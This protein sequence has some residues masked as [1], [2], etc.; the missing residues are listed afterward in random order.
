MAITLKQA[1]ALNG[2]PDLDSFND[3]QEQC[4]NTDY[5][6][7]SKPI[8]HLSSWEGYWYVAGYDL[9]ISLSSTSVAATGGTITVTYTIKEHR[10]TGDVLVSG[11][12]PTVTSTLGTVS[13]ITTTNTSGVGTATITIDN[14]KSL[15]SKS[16]KVTV[17]ST[18]GGSVISKES[19]ATQAA[20]YYTYGSITINTFTY[21]AVGAAGGTSSPSITY[22]QPYGWNGSTSGAGTINGNGDDDY[23][24]YKETGAHSALTVNGSTG[25]VTWTKNNATAN[26][27]DA[28]RSG[29]ITAT[30]TRNGKTAT[31]EVT[32][33][34]NA[35]K[36]SSYGAW[37]FTVKANTSSIAAT[38]GSVTFTISRPTR[39]VTYD[40]GDT[41]TETASAGTFALTR[42]NS[43]FTLSTTSISMTSSSL[44]TFTLSVGATGAAAV[45]AISSTVTAAFTAS[46]PTT[47]T[48]TKSITSSSVTRAASSLVGDYYRFSTFSVAKSSFTAATGTTTLSMV[49]QKR[50]KYTG[51]QY[52]SWATITPASGTLNVTAGTGGSV[53]SITYGATSTCTITVAQYTT[54][55]ANRTI[56]ISG[57]YNSGKATSS[58]DLSQTKDAIINTS[59]SDVTAGTISNKTIPASG[60]TTN[61]TATAGNGSQV[62]TYTWASGKANTTETKPIT[63]SHPSISATA[64]SRGT[65]ITNITTVKSQGVTWLGLDGTKKATGTMYIYQAGNYVTKLVLSSNGAMSFSYPTAS[66]AG[67]TISANVSGSWTRTF[68]FTSGA[69]SNSSPSSTYITSTS[70]KS[71]S[72]SASGNFAKPNSST[73]SIVVTGKGTSVSGVTSGSVVT[74]TYTQT[75]T[76]TSAYSAG[77]TV[78]ST[79]GVLTATP[80]QA[81][82]VANAYY[83]DLVLSLSYAAKGPSTSS[84]TSSPSLAVKAT[85]RYTSGSAGTQITVPTSGYNVT[86]KESTLSDYA[87]VN[88]SG[89]VTWNSNSK[90]TS[91]R[92]VGITAK[93]TCTP[94]YSSLS[95]STTATSKCNK[96]SKTTITYAVPTI[97][98]SYGN[99]AASAGT[100]SPSLSYSQARTQNWTSGA[101]D[102]LTPL[103]SGASSIKYTENS[104][105][106]SANAA[107]V[108][109]STGVIT[110]TS[111]C[112]KDSERTVGVTAEVKMNNKTGTKSITAKQ[113]ADTYTDS[114]VYKTEASLA[115]ATPT[116]SSG[117]TTL[118]V[119]VY[120]GK[121]RDWGCGTDG[122][123]QDY[124][125]YDT[126]PTVTDNKDW[127]SVG[128]FSKSSTGTYTATVTYNANSKNTSTRTAT[129]TAT[130]NSKSATAE[131]TQG[132]DTY[133]DSG[134]VTSTTY[135]N[136]RGGA[137]SFNS[138]TALSAAADSRT[139][140]IKPWSRTKTVK[141]TAKVREWKC[142]GTEI[143]AAET[144]TNSTEY[145]TGTVAVSE[146][147]SYTSLS[148]TS[149]TASSSAKTLKLTKT[150]C[151]ANI[152]SAATVTVTANPSTDG[153]ATTTKSIS[154]TANA[155]TKVAISVKSGTTP[156]PHGGG[157]VTL[158]CKGTFTSGTHEVTPSWTGVT[159]GT[160]S[161]TTAKNPT[162]TVGANSG[163][164]RDVTVSAKYP[165]DSTG[166]I[167][168]FTIKQAGVPVNFTLPIDFYV[169]STRGV[170]GAADCSFKCSGDAVLGSQSRQSF[171]FN[172]GLIRDYYVTGGSFKESKVLN[173]ASLNVTTNTT[174]FN[175]YHL[176]WGFALHASGGYGS[177]TSSTIQYN[178]YWQI[179][180]YDGTIYDLMSTSYPKT[181][182]NYVSVD[183][184]TTNE[185][186]TQSSSPISIANGDRIR[187]TIVI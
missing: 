179:E 42:S 80:K 107:T 63:P 31:K 180:K 82:N 91:D 146:N 131:L 183:Y 106:D 150:T 127:V 51:D 104:N 159:N 120:R 37:S 92:T 164:E 38:G 27:V 157:T 46:S 71:F 139:V 65:T 32:T 147:G 81:A 169:Q 75:I 41:Q 176:D 50:S 30:V 2:T 152:T 177:S 149:Y 187:I 136:W 185:S 85:P 49:V 100:V 59:Y 28:S 132:K 168:S 137:I 47:G 86:W 77:G 115:N 117:T 119:K 11:V 101:T 94:T 166:K 15:S 64:E 134:G 4:K 84:M 114:W 95:G 88:T 20:G 144:S 160:L 56:T 155:L 121:Y 122:M 111:N 7:D 138:T 124:A 43:N 53:G 74:R 40:T 66:A 181:S 143:L 34:Q 186:H 69:T 170:S 173:L 158:Q 105:S 89:V 156:I 13:N 12:K 8:N 44:P 108:A 5:F 135:G 70:S 55:T 72:G 175:D 167:A 178:L 125:L 130:A 9:S 22:S 165:N 153:P 10:S 61:Y 87:S 93:V 52:T 113:L 145:Y 116:C 54:T 133:T 102:T 73:G 76:H 35:E 21:G 118:T 83:T 23:T 17:S 182:T 6:S 126:T 142:G 123:I 99:R 184:L 112:G 128:S 140:T 96:D 151:G 68:T 98:F 19:T 103:T 29:K 26:T 161:S 62:L 174:N 110:W 90:V 57:N 148:A 172:S 58:L 171:S 129:I 79:G 39:T 48:T 16:I 25:V 67:E 18:L 33:T 14:N 24:T 162:L 109:K 1:F 36:I 141:T 97:T 78:S 3:L 60:T 163:A 45:A 154:Q